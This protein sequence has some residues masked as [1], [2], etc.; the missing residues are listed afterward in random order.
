MILWI[1]AIFMIF[2]FIYLVMFRPEKQVQS[3]FKYQTIEDLCSSVSVHMRDR[4]YM[5][6]RKIVSHEQF[7]NE[8]E[9]KQL[10]RKTLEKAIGG[11]YQARSVILDE[12]QA[13]LI[14]TSMNIETL[15]D[16]SC[17]LFRSPDAMLANEKFETMLYFLKKEI[18]DSL[19]LEQTYDEDNDDVRKAFKKFVEFT[20]VFKEKRPFKTDPTLSGYYINDKDLSTHFR[21]FLVEKNIEI[22]VADAVAITAILIYQR[23]FG[24]GVV[25]TIVYDN[26]IDEIQLGTSGATVGSGRHISAPTNS[27]MIAM[28][29][30]T[31]RLQCISFHSE[32]AYQNAII[33]LASNGEKTFTADDGYK[34]TT[35]HDMRRITAR[36]PPAADKFAVNIRRLSASV[37]TNRQLLEMNPTIP[38]N[39]QLVQ[40]TLQIMAWTMTTFCWTG[41]QGSGKTSH[42][43]AFCNLLDA[44]VG[45]RALG[46]IDE[47]Q[48]GNRYPERDAQHLFETPRQSLHSIAGMGRRTRGTFLILMEVIDAESG[49]EAINNFKS[50]YIGGMMTGHGATT[51]AMIE[52]MAQLLAMGQSTSTVET[53]KIVANV[54]K[55]NVKTAKYGS[56]FHY[57]AITEIIPRDWNVNWE[58]VHPDN[59]QE[60]MYAD[61][62]Q[63]LNRIRAINDQLYFQNSLNP[64][65]YATQAIVRFNKETLTYEAVHR[66]SP[67]LCVQWFFAIDPSRRKFLFDYLENYFDV[68]LA[69]ELIDNKHV[70]VDS[71]EELLKFGA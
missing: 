52:F 55:L 11:S 17:V 19:T 1:I 67:G 71:K 22:T 68:D 44:D 62:E 27:A 29:N 26:S 60:A 66:P 45:I 9:E 54:L 65:L 31:L 58:L 20:G 2:A 14:G 38:G 3:V 34:Y 24:F 69:Q 5:Q 18:Q 46:N 70:F 57:E 40:D 61:A 59:G 30:R 15:D 21:R 37:V 42:V 47:S 13:F 51:E 50:G 48:F 23:L 7:I 49:Q 36:R 63:N 56:T 28:S 41:E 53:T 33:S 39:T 64:L 8:I 35:L 12:I 6:K 32:A 43:N 4:L 10:L 16:L 25:D